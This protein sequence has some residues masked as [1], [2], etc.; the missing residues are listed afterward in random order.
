MPAAAGIP[1]PGQGRQGWIRT[2]LIGNYPGWIFGDFAEAKGNFKLF[3]KPKG[4]FG[5]FVEF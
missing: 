2:S 5:G 3:L 1:T 4:N